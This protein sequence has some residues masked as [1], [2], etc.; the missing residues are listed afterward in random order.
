MWNNCLVE[1]C[2]FSV[3]DE[4]KIAE[5]VRKVFDKAKKEHASHSRFAL[6]N[7]VSD[8]SNLS[9]K[10]LERAYDRYI[11]GKRKHG[12]SSAE[13]VNLFCNYLEY[14]NYGAYVKS[15]PDEGNIKLPP[16]GSDKKRKLIIAMNLVVGLVLL[17]FGIKNW[18][19]NYPSIDDT[20]TECMTWADSLYVK[21]SCEE[22][23]LSKYGTQVKPLDIMELKN[24]KKLKVNAA[25]SFFTE[26]GKPLVWYY[27]KSNKEIEYFRAPGLHPTNG[28][29]LRKIT[30][31]IIQTYVPIHSINQES[32]IE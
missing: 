12:P 9:S 19:T 14:E 22:G 31:Y 4:N 18:S 8:K 32:F 2:I 16:K 29:T 23:P 25:Y 10:T 26:D 13:S 27:K 3:M 17:I 20:R 5:I 24:M 11:D 15:N 6:S 30:P 1:I 28:E 21:I 7:F